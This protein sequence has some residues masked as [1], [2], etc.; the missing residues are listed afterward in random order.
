MSKIK[1]GD[2]KPQ[3]ENVLVDVKKLEEVSGE[4][5]VGNQNA[6]D[7]DAM[8]IEFFIGE[9]KDFGESATSKNQCPELAKG[10]F[11]FFSQFSGYSI[12]TE[13]AYA[14]VLPGYNIIAISED[15]NMDIKTIKPTNDRVLVEILKESQVNEGVFTGDSQDP[16][17][18]NIARGKIL[19]C[20]L[21]ANQYPEGTIIAFEPF[22]GNYIIKNN[23]QEIKTINSSDILFTL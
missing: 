22:C 15:M 1:I 16:R 19:S 4:I 3:N 10:K 17:D 21:N 23:E 2:V 6:V 11:A 5:Y 12:P 8:P 18:S 9:V 14:K 20:G 13:D 7:N